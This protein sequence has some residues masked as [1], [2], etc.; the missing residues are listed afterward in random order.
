MLKYL[1]KFSFGIIL[2]FGSFSIKGQETGIPAIEKA[3]AAKEFKKADSI[4]QPI[5]KRFINE[6]RPDSLLDYVFYEGKVTQGRK[7]LQAGI[8]AVV[9]LREKI[10]SLTKDPGIIRQAY[11]E[12]GQFYGTNGMNHQGY[13][14]NI[15]AKKYVLLM[16]GMAE[17]YQGLIENNLS[18]YA[19]RIGDI[20][21]AGKHSRAAIKILTSIKN[22]NPETLYIAYNGMGATMWYASRSDSALYFYNKALETLAKAEPTPIN[23]Y[24]R[25]ATIQNNISGLYSIEG[26][27]TKAIITLNQS[28]SNLRN[29]ITSSGSDPKKESAIRFQF[30]SMDN[31]AGIHKE[32]GD[33]KKARALLEYSYQQ[34]QLN[35]EAGDPG[36]F[37][38]EIL[39]GQLYF[40]TR[41][42]DKSLL[43][44]QKGLDK[45]NASAGDYLIW[46]AEAYSTM[47][48]IYDVK[49]D[50]VK[51]T[52]FYEKTDSL[53]EA[54][55]QGSYDYIYLDFL[56]NTAL[57]YAENHQPAKAIQ[58]ANKGYQYVA[59][60]QGTQTLL[61]FYQLLN[62]A[63][64]AY[65][66]G[67]YRQA[68]DYSSRGLT[69]LDNNIH[70]SESRLDSIRM[71]LKKPKAILQ[72]GKA[73]YELLTKK[74]EKSLTL[75]LDEMNEALSV[76]DRQ[77]TILTDP[78]DIGFLVSDHSD[79]VEFIKKLNLELYNS[80]KNPKYIDR[81]V[82]MHEAGMYNRIRARLE[83]NDSIQYAHVSKNILLQEQLYKNEITRSLEGN[84]S[85]GSSIK[86]FQAALIKQE[87][88]RESLKKDFPEYYNLR[89]ASIFRSLDEIKG[90][91]PPNTTLIR[92][93]FIDK[94]LYVLVADNKNKTLHALKTEN[95]EKQVEA[96][97]SN[98]LD[99]NAVSK[100]LH[101][102]YQSLWA[103][104]AD[105]IRYQKVVIIPDGY[106]YNLNFELLTPKPI[107]KFTDLA[108]YSL[109]ADYT[110]SY[111]Y[112]LFLL[113]QQERNMKHQNAFI[114]FAPGFTD[115]LKTAYR[116]VSKDSFEIDNNYLSLLPQP[117]SINLAEKAGDLLGGKTFTYGKS[118]KEFFKENAG[119]HQI[120]HIG[121]HAESNNDYPQYSRLIFAK[122]ISDSEEDNSLYVDEIYNYNLAANLAVLTACETGKPGFQDGEGM[123]SLAHAFNYAGSESILT[124]LWKIDE[125]ASS[126]VL[127]FFY[128]NILK[129]MAKDEALRQAKLSYL[130]KAEGRMLAPQYWAGLVI[131][132]DTSPIVM[133]KQKA[134]WW[135]VPG[136]V[137]MLGVAGYVLWRRK[138]K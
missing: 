111:H 101:S 129:G 106:L 33:L 54:S 90:K 126:L 134:P 110:I 100:I 76:L 9:S 115:E 95:V 4:L 31:L 22:A 96:F 103:P 58:K 74:D 61:A 87:N 40:A 138:K 83:R 56:R 116:S 136:L 24:Y 120:I 62:L 27:T 48:L 91:I 107:S 52:Y 80:T 68:L 79:L 21:L 98:S 113:Q 89:Y 67:N 17:N 117:F 43:F 18:T 109:L 44:L 93:F 105:D 66:S 75:L 47:A 23:K 1:L 114:A 42:Y 16:P 60:T 63:E 29:F 77:K 3:I 37:I 15:Q 102:L 53:Y 65:L 86:P 85:S 26:N 125:Q 50:P 5:I 34:K 20:D 30:Q 32:M 8:K 19:Q 81:A 45:I 119:G 121:T 70:K 131:M 69:V 99:V 39:L 41:N 49:K 97:L 6:N 12:E 36:I 51:A 127:S 55:L 78:E 122:N 88:F 128:E 11:I 130:S 7:D 137:I 57:F 2:L 10:K 46:E 59:S 28:I 14:A 71:E 64:V 84:M 108:R 118:T 73:G 135:M 124:G 133:K 112:S 38:S 82:S 94:K 72:K 104:I 35:M 25:S 92:Y 13:Q 132:G 123:I